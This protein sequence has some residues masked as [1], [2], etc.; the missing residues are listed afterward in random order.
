MEKELQNLAV[1]V[2]KQRFGVVRGLPGE[3]ILCNSIEYQSS[4]G[5]K[6]LN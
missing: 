6:S 3:F 4:I 5:S 2:A 1:Q